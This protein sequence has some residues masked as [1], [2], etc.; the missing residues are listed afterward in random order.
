M[1]T[2]PLCARSCSGCWLIP[3]WPRKTR[4]PSSKPRSAMRM[5]TPSWRSCATSASTAPRSDVVG[6]HGQTVYHRPEAVH[7]PARRR[8]AHG[9]AHWHRRRST[10]SA[11]P[12][13]PRAAKA[14][15]SRRST[16][17]RWRL[18]PAAA[19]DGAEPRRRRQRHLYRRRY[20]DRVRHRP[21]LRA[22]RRFRAEAA[23][24]ELRRGWPAG[25]IR[26]RRT[27]RS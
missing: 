9:R 15:P 3:P 19:L 16:T 18:R 17:A 23:G 12:T 11:M 1:P 4:W 7:A 10:A 8:P 5:P 25:G 13:W 6:L 21:G 2:T 20:G 22:A 14:R 26:G 24:Q 27:R